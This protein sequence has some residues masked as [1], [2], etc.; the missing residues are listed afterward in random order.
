[1]R[2]I[3]MTMIIV[4]MIIVTMPVMTMVIVAV[5][6]CGDLCRFS[7][8]GFGGLRFHGGMRRFRMLRLLV[9]VR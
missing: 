9:V 1:M 6:V 3:V 4:T 8:S 7:Q 5:I 2:M